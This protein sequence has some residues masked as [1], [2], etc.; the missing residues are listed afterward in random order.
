MEIYVLELYERL[1]M[2][3][4]NSGPDQALLELEL[5]VESRKVRLGQVRSGFILTPLDFS[6]LVWLGK[7]NFKR[8]C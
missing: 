8:S 6:G 7:V 5:G 3:Q 1:L 4:H 2:S